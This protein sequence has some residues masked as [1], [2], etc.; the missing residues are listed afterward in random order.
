M[1]VGIFYGIAVFGIVTQ[2]MLHRQ[3]KTRKHHEGAHPFCDA[4]SRRRLNQLSS[5]GDR[6]G[7]LVSGHPKICQRGVPGWWDTPR[8]SHINSKSSRPSK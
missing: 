6:G 4:L 5:G 7:V 2:K 1:P 3:N 8:F